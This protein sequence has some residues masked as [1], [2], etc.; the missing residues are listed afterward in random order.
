MKPIGLKKRS[1]GEIMIIHECLTC[2]KISPNRIAGDDFPDAIL[3]LLSGQKG[4]N[5]TLLNE[6][7]V[8]EV[9]SALFGNTSL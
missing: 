6:N 8:Y 7:D 4:G 5:H 1:D 2:G 3:S 9:R